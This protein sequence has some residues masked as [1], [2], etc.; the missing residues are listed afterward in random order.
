MN[1]AQVIK[2]FGGVGATAR[3]LGL[4]QPAVSVWKRNGRISYLRQL[5]IQEV[6]NG[7][8]KAEARK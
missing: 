2:F 8:L 6:T 7:K 4:S 5:Q 3:A 1:P